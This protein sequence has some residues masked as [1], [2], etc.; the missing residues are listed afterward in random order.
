MGVLGSGK[1]KGELLSLT[2]LVALSGEGCGVR[3][4]RVFASD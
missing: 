3:A 4:V 1:I 2:K